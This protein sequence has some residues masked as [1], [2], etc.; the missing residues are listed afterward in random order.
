MSKTLTV[1][2]GER[3][4]P[5]H[6]GRGLAG[7]LQDQVS[8]MKGASRPLALVYD[9]ELGRVQD[10]FLKQAFPEIPRLALP[11]GE[12]TKSLAHWGEVLEFLADIPLDRTGHLF[13]AGGGVVGDLGGFAAAAYLRGIPF[14]LV[15]TTL[16]S[17]VDSSVGG[18]TGINLPAG[19]NL[20]G[21]F[22]QPSSV[23]ID[24]D[25][26][27]TLPPREFTAGMAEVIK[28]GLLGNRALFE[29][30]ETESVLHSGHSALE[31]IIEECCR[32]KA[33]IVQ[34]DERETASSGGR[35]LLNLGHT[36][37][38]AVEAV[39][40]YGKTLHGE[41][42]GLGLILAARLSES[43]GWLSSEDSDRVHQLV[44]RYGLPQRLRESLPI[45][46]LI[47]AMKRDK[48]AK[49]GRLR[50]VALR[51]LG[52]AE[53]NDNVSEKTIRDLWAGVGAKD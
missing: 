36:F 29:K 35:A 21:A 24:V 14:H 48:K 8:K 2:L 32:Q 15:P 1:E 49:F 28:Y 10:P 37:A 7:P 5:I 39:D 18:K 6:I 22:F 34:A 53:T 16:L 52:V 25:L 4:Y 30:L 51:E 3:S 27:S 33:A 19:K 44:A 43:L 45:E 47:S 12:S 41:A 20:V 26:L 38:H 40:G 11:S 50:F 17:M 42:V 13:V 46:K 31:E 9:Q 23:T